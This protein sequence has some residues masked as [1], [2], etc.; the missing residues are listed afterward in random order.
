MFGRSKTA[1]VIHAVAA[2]MTL[3]TYSSFSKLFA[4]IPDSRGPSELYMPCLFITVLTVFIMLLIN[5]PKWLNKRID[6]ENSAAPSILGGEYTAK[7][8]VK[9]PASNP[10]KKNKKK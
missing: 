9:K 1:A 6:E 10:S 8:T 3:I 7:K 2:I 5:F 4:E